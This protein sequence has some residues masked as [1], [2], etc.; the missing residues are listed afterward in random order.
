MAKDFTVTSLSPMPI[1]LRGG[2]IREDL[3]IIAT[4]DSVGEIIV[5]VKPEESAPEAVA[6]I[7][8]AEVDRRKA[9]LDL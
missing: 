5:R 2:V 4:T 7:I 8:Q 9:L 3:Q 6:A 1:V